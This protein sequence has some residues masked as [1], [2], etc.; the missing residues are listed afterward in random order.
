MPSYCRTIPGVYIYA[1][2]FETLHN[3]DLRRLGAIAT[4]YTWCPA[5]LAENY[6]K[7]ANFLYSDF[8]GFDVDNTEGEP[9]T[10]AQAM[11]DWADS[12]CVI[13]I[14]R[15]H[16]KEK[17]TGG[18]IHPPA[19][20]FRII[21]Q[22][23]RRIETIEEFEYN[24]RL[25]LKHNEP[26]DAA[27]V[28]A[29]RCFYPSQKIVFANFDGIKQPVK[30]IEKKEKT[31]AE[32]AYEYM[33]SKSNRIPSHVDSFIKK[34]IVFGDG[35]NKS[36]YVSTLE[37]LSAGTD[38]EKVLELLKKSPFDRREFPDHELENTYVSAL[39]RFVQA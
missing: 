4:K 8:V 18:T 25:I 32:A 14:T 30:Q 26:F 28:D 5:A 15:S 21:T 13:A 12:V 17:N 19:D 10:L 29:T 22:W 34:G 1:K 38:P 35:R 27:C 39:K 11:E 16:Q 23:E 33:K 3:C 31:I 37:L 9:Y 24:T 20:R 7:K 2:D 36:V 6:R